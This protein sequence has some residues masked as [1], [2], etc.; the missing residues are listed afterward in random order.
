[1]KTAC[2]TVKPGLDQRD[3]AHACCSTWQRDSDNGDIVE[4][5]AATIM[6][7]GLPPELLEL[8]ITE[9]TIME[10]AESD[11]YFRSA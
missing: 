8:E 3:S 1:M 6:R 4:R 5:V 10:N 7:N 11:C 2:V 9:S